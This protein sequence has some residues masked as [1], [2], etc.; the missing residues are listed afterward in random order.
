MKVV[1]I[2]SSKDSVKASIPPASSAEDRFGKMTRRNVCQPSAPKSIEASM[3]EP[4]V[5]RSRAMALLWTTT[6][7][8]V[9]WPTT[10]V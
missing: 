2:T 9:A 3:M 1:T 6:T 7:Q 8:K 5:R 10:M 4:A